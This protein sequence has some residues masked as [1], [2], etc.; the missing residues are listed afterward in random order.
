MAAQTIRIQQ[1]VFHVSKQRRY[2]RALGFPRAISD[3]KLTTFAHAPGVYSWLQ[4]TKTYGS[5]QNFV[6][7]KALLIQKQDGLHKR[8]QTHNTD[9]KENSTANFLTV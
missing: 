5:C 2:N 3:S 1:F 7:K 9:S 4:E 6:E 8:T